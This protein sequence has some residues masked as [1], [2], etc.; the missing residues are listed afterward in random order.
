MRIFIIKKILRENKWFAIL[1][2]YEF[3][4]NQVGSLGYVI[5]KDENTL[6][7]NRIYKS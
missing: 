1:R 7:L 4:L 5:S 2:K 6:D 3:W